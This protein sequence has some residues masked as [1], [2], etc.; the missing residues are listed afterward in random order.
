MSAKTDLSAEVLAEHARITDAITADVLAFNVASGGLTKASIM[1]NLVAKE[2][3]KCKL[4]RYTGDGFADVDAMLTKH[5]GATKA[6]LKHGA[7]VADRLH[8]AK[9]TRDHV[10]DVEK[11]GNLQ[12]VLKGIN[13]ENSKERLEFAD[14]HTTEECKNGPHA[15]KSNGRNGNGISKVEKAQ[16]AV[17]NLS[18]E[19]L[20]IFAAWYIETHQKEEEEVEEAA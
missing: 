11:P 16:K 3:S 19:E 1:L 18:K 15:P 5:F 6:M 20:V 10:A 2:A 12:Y 4:F 8:G 13:A 17:G 14:A 7:S 9:V